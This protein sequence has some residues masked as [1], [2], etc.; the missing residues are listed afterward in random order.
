[1]DIIGLKLGYEGIFEEVYH[2]F[3]ERLYA[4]FLKHTRSPELSAELVQQVFIRLWQHRARLSE[5]HTLSEQLFRIAK[6]TFIDMLRKEK[7]QRQLMDAYAQTLDTP[8]STPGHHAD[9]EKQLH[10]EMD[11]M[12][13][14]RKKVF[15]LSRVEGLSHKEIS[16]QLSIAPKTVEAHIS[17]ALK[18]LRKALVSALV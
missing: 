9:I 5:T 1:M 10:R 16:E 14:V 12:P 7:Y 17:K 11:K 15:W 6:T 8:A 3:H 13:P 2:A 4:Y 18:Q